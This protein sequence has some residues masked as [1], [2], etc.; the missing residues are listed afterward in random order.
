MSIA[1]KLSLIAEN[2]QKVYNAGYQKGKAEGGDTEEAYNQGFEEGK[3]SQ[4]DEFWT[5]YQ[6]EGNRKNY[7][8]GFCGIGWNDST[9]KPKYK[10]Q[11]TGNIEQMFANSMITDISDCDIDFSKA[12][13]FNN[14]MQSSQMVTVGEIN[15]TG[16]NSLSSIFR[17]ASYLTTIKKLIL[18]DDGSQTFSDAFYNTQTLTNITEI[19][20]EIGKNISFNYSPKLTKDSVMIIVNALKD[21]SGTTTTATLTLHATTKALLTEN[22]IAII[23]QKGWTL[24]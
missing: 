20:G 9:F 14:F 5:N 18:K 16:A 12:T 17:H 10:I 8:R 21:Y 15:T 19:I 23:T 11:P 1:E 7:I 22:D 2:E 24:A 13:T 6:N 4:Y 3:K